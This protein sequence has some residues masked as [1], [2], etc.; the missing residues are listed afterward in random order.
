MN[1]GGTENMIMNL[2]RNIDREKIQFD[3]LV[4]S[5]E[6]CFFDEE[7]KKLGGKIYY[8][9]R[10]RATNTFNYINA[11]NSFFDAHPEYKI[12]HGHIASS[13]AIYLK[14]ARKRG[15]YTISHS[16]NIKG[17]G[18][19]PKD[20][21]F[22]LV[23]LSQRYL[24][25]YLFACSEK[26]GTVRF[27]KSVI[28]K[29]N[30]KVL[31]NAIDLARY[32]RDDQKKEETKNLYNISG[33][34]VVGHIGRFVEAKNHAFILDVFSK[35]VLRRPDSVLLLLGEGPLENEI[36]TKA[37]SLEISDKII[38]AGVVSDVNNLI[39]VMDCFIFPSL[40]EG[41][42]ISAIEAQSHGIP[43][44][45][46]NTLPNDLLINPNVYPLSLTLSPDDWAEFVI[47][48]NKIIP[49]DVSIKNIKNAGY[50]IKETADFLENFYIENP[51]ERI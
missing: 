17:A 5:K 14:I 28:H 4:N 22:K 38:Y 30:F 34:F 27:G 45:I 13:S 44:F 19:T 40:H 39:N 18:R 46:N 23:T 50:D 8:I 49:A 7:I 9:P 11:L 37:K 42:G 36:K 35:I 33:K 20:F 48:N 16:H 31:K 6:S 15:I 21:I 47:E 1:C 25:N 24:S 29:D 3:F 2:Y 32:S 10:W 43:C 12:I 26:A 41:L 51:K